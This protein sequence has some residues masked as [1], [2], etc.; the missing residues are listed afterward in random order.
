M[1][2]DIL[3]KTALTGILITAAVWDLKT[4]RVP[5]AITWGL[6]MGA[7]ALI[8]IRPAGV[9]PVSRIGKS[10]PLPWGWGGIPLAREGWILPLLLVGLLLIERMP[11]AWQ[12]PVLTFLVVGVRL[13]SLAL[14]GHP[15]ISFVAFWWGAVYALWSLHVVGGA[16]ARIFMGLVA[17]FPRA[18][19]VAA[20]SG[21][22]LSV[23]IAWLFVTHRGG[24]LVSLIEARERMCRG[25]FP[26]RDE[27]EEQGLP[28]TPGLALGALV[29][30]WLIH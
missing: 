6:L 17:L 7:T 24:A 20:L 8:M 19:L 28:T 3:I 16:D 26:S 9:C 15:A 10:D 29:F 23:S 30:L 27:L 12:F 2:T 4:R 18:E 14:G 11:I 13:G 21:G 1:M 25:Q 5:H 22:L